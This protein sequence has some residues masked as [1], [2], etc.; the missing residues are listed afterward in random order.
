MEFKIQN[1][2]VFCKN[3]NLV[4]DNKGYKAF[5]DFDSEWDGIVK[6]ARFIKGEEHEDRVINNG[7]CYIPM[8]VM[9][10]GFFQ[11]GVY[12]TGIATTQCDAY[13]AESVKENI[14]DHPD[15]EESVFDQLL[16]AMAETEMKTSVYTKESEGW[17]HGR[18]D[19]PEREKDN[20][21]YYASQARD[22]VI[23][24]PGKV[25]EAKRRIDEYVDGKEEALKGET[26]NL[27]FAAFRVVG[28]RLK[29]YSDPN[30][31]K[32]RFVRHGSRL[33][34]RLTF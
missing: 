32:V 12:S 9:K 33:A 18:E 30:V 11:V 27:F 16:N 6:I 14:G 31:D 21:A 19:M 34:Y 29:A 4:G 22:A 13:V 10:Q 15:P 7:F 26:G 5:F 24:I 23:G 2:R 1:K 25:E 3:E 17:A 8:F 28:S 20:A